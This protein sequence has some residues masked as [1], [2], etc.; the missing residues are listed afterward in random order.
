MG[1]NHFRVT[2]KRNHS[3]LSALAGVIVSLTHA[4]TSGFK[5]HVCDAL[6]ACKVVYLS[7]LPFLLCFYH[8]KFK[9]LLFFRLKGMNPFFPQ[10]SGV[11]SVGF[12]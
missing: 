7:S 3:L 10:L 5:Q 8:F 11:F 1:Q 6:S 4:G 2:F 12:G 9:F